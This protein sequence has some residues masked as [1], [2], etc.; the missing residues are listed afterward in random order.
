M[1]AT[2]FNTTNVN[3]QNV[4]ATG[5]VSTPRIVLSGDLVVA[6]IPVTN[7]MMVDM[8]STT[9]SGRTAVAKSLQYG[10]N[11]SIFDYMHFTPLLNS[12][13]SGKGV[14]VGHFESEL[15]FRAPM[16]RHIDSRTVRPTGVANAQDFEMADTGYSQHTINK[17]HGCITA[18]LI[19]GYNTHSYLKPDVYGYST[20]QGS[21]QFVM[22][23]A[24]NADVTSFPF[25]V[26]VPTTT[27]NFL[28]DDAL[29]EVIEK[30]WAQDVQVGS[31]SYLFRSLNDADELVDSSN[32]SHNGISNALSY[33]FSLAADHDM[34]LC[35]AA[36]NY[37]PTEVSCKVASPGT[38]YITYGSDARNILS[39]GTH[40]VAENR[41]YLY[42]YYIYD[43]SGTTYYWVPGLPVPPGV[44]T[45]GIQLLPYCGYG[46][47]EDGRVKPDI[48]AAYYKDSNW[49]PIG[50]K[51]VEPTATN[52][53]NTLEYQNAWGNYTSFTCP[54][55]AAGVALLREALPKLDAHQIRECIMCS[56]VA[57]TTSSGDVLSTMPNGTGYGLINTEAA[58]AYGQARPQGKPPQLPI[59][60]WY[61]K[62][63]QSSKCPRDTSGNTEYQTQY[64][65]Y[66][67]LY[68]AYVA[69]ATSLWTGAVLDVSPPKGLFG[70]SATRDLN[71]D[72][73]VVK[74]K[75]SWICVDA[76][77]MQTVKDL[78][79][80]NGIKVG[81]TSSSLG[82]F[83]VDADSIEQ[84]SAVVQQSFA[85]RSV[86][87]VKQLIV[88]LSDMRS[89]EEEA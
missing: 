26:D 20:A 54:K 72:G 30:A 87:P 42:N 81:Y 57:Y 71:L 79:V 53:A 22:G 89:E 80:S 17:Y 6:N 65:A 63:V 32:N 84:L 23:P 40:R 35:V 34:V 24:Y 37:M 82:A 49:A 41:S 45:G 86:V 60:N 70:T 48:L 1:S 8:L 29:I 68:N 51:A 73:Q 55:A 64:A 85:I 50:D 61:P 15:D 74:S 36:G 75:K 14:S 76:E 28:A 69:S 31:L 11:K 7:T 52:N 4:N 77:N 25:V 39:V 3:T 62:S 58:L 43:S 78:M 13:Y 21:N 47:T 9:Q 12:G 19:A 18:S 44:A 56:T 46:K 5:T 66:E 10:P 16:F 67:I 88:S 33:V 83:S 59:A 27:D 2:N 38:G